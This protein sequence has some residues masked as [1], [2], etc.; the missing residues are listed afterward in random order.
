MSLFCTYNLFFS[1]DGKSQKRALISDC[2]ITLVFKST[3]FN[4]FPEI[5]IYS[6][7]YK[8]KRVL[9]LP[10]DLDLLHSLLQ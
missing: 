2:K 3:V 10:T 8:Q 7:A 4:L 5:V 1:K 9:L 6:G